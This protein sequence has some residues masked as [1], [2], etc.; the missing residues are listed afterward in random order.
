MYYMAFS[1][2]L[3]NS[4]TILNEYITYIWIINAVEV[5]GILLITL[6]P[7]SYNVKRIS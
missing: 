2:W 4:I 1:Y 7:S 3:S 5:L 6:D